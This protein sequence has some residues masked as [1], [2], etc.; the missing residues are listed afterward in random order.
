MIDRRSLIAGVAAMAA[1]SKADASILRT[2]VVPYYTAPVLIWPGALSGSVARYRNGLYE[3]AH[4]IGTKSQVLP[5]DSGSD[6]WEKAAAYC[7]LKKV[8][9]RVVIGHSN[10]VIACTHFAR[11]VEPHGI[12]V[13]MVVMDKTLLPCPSLGSNVVSCM[14][15]Y[16]GLSHVLKG[17]DFTGKFFSYD[18]T[19]ESHV[20]LTYNLY[21]QR[22]AANFAD[23]W[24][25]NMGIG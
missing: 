20:G 10:G 9:G 16:A 23:N 11:A 8:K 21:A 6:G 22:L 1:A 17:N 4:K 12:K 13:A 19:D 24:A 5:S 18:F 14:E 3:I 25:R 2:Q 15:L 7:V